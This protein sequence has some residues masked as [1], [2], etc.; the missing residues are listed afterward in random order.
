MLMTNWNVPGTNIIWKMLFRTGIKK[1]LKISDWTRT[2]KIGK[3]R[4]DSLIKTI[5]MKPAFSLKH[6]WVST[7]LVTPLQIQM[8]PY[9]NPFPLLIEIFESVQ[10]VT[11]CII[12][13]SFRSSISTSNPHR[14]STRHF[15]HPFSL[16]NSS[17]SPNLIPCHLYIFL[18]SVILYKIE[19]FFVN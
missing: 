6:K 7:L 19:F 10:C 1:N 3:S 9:I 13:C 12:K 17:L 4:T 8:R 15:S 2:K 5:V 14:M 16:A 11:H 18:T